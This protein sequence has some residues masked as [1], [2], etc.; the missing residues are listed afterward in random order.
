MKTLTKTLVGTAAAGALAVSSAAPAFARDRHD[1][2]IGAGEVIAGALIIGGIAAVAAA[3]SKDKND[4]YG[5]HGDRYRDYRYNGR[6]G[7]RYGYGNS[8]SAVDQCVRAAERNAGRYGYA[9][10]TRIRDVDRKSYG[11]KVKGNIAVNDRGHRGSRYGWNGRNGYDSGKFSC[12]ISH[13]RV[14]DLDYSGIRGL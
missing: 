5:Y 13:G 3:A 2:G 7:R 4:G 14:V 9:N 1:G 6:D 8:R 11:Y 10:V 12:K